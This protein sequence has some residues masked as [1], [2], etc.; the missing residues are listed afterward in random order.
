[1]NIVHITRTFAVALVLVLTATGLW[2]TGETESAAAEAEM[3]TVELMRADGTMMTK[4]VEKPRYGGMY[5]ESIELALPA[6]SSWV[7]GD[8][9]HTTWALQVTNE[10][11]LQVD[12]ARGASGTGDYG[13][14]LA[15]TPDKKTGALVES[16]EQPSLTRIIL[17][18]RPGVPFWERGD[19]ARPNDALASAYGRDIDAHDLVFSWGQ[20]FI[21]T[22]GYHWTAVDDMTVEI[23]LDE[24]DATQ[25][26]FFFAQFAAVVPRETE[27]LNMADWRNTLGTGAFIPTEMTPGSVVTFK[28]NENYWQTDHIH[29]ENQLPYLDGMRIVSFEDEAGIIAALRSGKL[30]RTAG[31]GIATRWQESLEETNP[32]ILS[33][34]AIINQRV[35][36]VRLDI[37]GSP[38]QNLLVRQAAHLAIPHAEIRDEFYQGNALLFGWPNFPHHA[39]LYV[40]FE[41]L[42]TSPQISGS[43]ASAR[44]LFEF[45]P[46]KARELLARAGY[47]DG[48]TFE[49]LTQPTDVE[50][51]ELYAGYWDDV[52]IKADF[53]VVES[54]VFSS[55]IAAGEHQSMIATSWGNWADPY[56]VM[57]QYYDP[58]NP[59]NY[60]RGTDERVTDAY[61]QITQTLDQDEL[62]RQF[63][64]TAVYIVEN[65]VVIA[66]VPEAN[67]QFWQPWVKGYSGEL[68]GAGIQGWHDVAK[69]VWVDQDLREQITGSR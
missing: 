34:P 5:T 35:F 19:V 33:G 54:T 13:V 15:P 1:M 66:G 58:G 25:A 68:I 43:G 59:S 57:Q 52:G 37:E 16:W 42:P 3:V 39:P 11:L 10:R 21:K 30:D 18:V 28:K 2:A 56:S 20:Y 45:D 4:E 44:E 40:P 48:F 31:L 65:A 24:P 60:S 69:H 14:F 26:Q 62:I 7:T 49:L 51:A 47:P 22:L 53:N 17:H 8:P 6:E 27:G 38:W 61:R 67:L 29:P 55:S 63:Q 12:W 32:E 46:D 36:N 50:W 23:T 9:S 41:E 64:E